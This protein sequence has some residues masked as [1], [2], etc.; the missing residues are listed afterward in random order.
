MA[1]P[2]MHCY[3]A[4]TFVKRILLLWLNLS[5]KMT[6][7][8]FWV[9]S[10]IIEIKPVQLISTNL[11]FQTKKSARQTR[12]KTGCNIKIVINEKIVAKKLSKLITVWLEV[13]TLEINW[14][15]SK[16]CSLLSDLAWLPQCFYFI[17]E[18]AIKVLPSW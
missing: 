16:H 9:S 12:K 14:I 15:P 7:A 1:C 3:L 8:P 13:S 11:N 17:F 4:L 6:K 18:V 5:D 10:F 2:D